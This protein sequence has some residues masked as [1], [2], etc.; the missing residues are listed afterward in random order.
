M[1]RFVFRLATLVR[2]KEITEKQQKMEL[3]A[4]QTIL[5][6][7]N[8]ELTQ[9]NQDRALKIT[10]FRDDIDKG[11]MEMYRF[12]QF[13][14]YL[15]YMKDRIAQKQEEIKAAQAKVDEC[16]AALVITQN[17]LKVLAKLRE[18][19]YAEYLAQAALEEEKELADTMSFKISKSK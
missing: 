1:K 9:L 3:T 15:Q 2:V 16:V 17:E 12:T 18:K 14:Y 8:R 7:K 19:Q 11:H 4:A 6:Q 5:N 13:S 10:A